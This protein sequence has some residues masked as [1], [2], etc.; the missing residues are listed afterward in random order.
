MLTEKNT[1]RV[2]SLDGLRGFA[3][4]TVLL[5]HYTYFRIGWVT[6]SLF[7]V[8]SAYLITSRLLQL[9]HLPWRAY[10]TKFFVARVARIFPLYFLALSLGFLSYRILQWPEEWPRVFPFLATFTFNLYPMVTGDELPYV[11]CHFWSLATE[12]QF[13]LLW[14]FLVLLIPRTILPAVACLFLIAAPL[15]RYYL[16]ELF[17]TS[18]PEELVSRSIYYFPL[19]HIDALGL[20]ILMATHGTSLVNALPNEP[21]KS[22]PMFR[23]LLLLL[24]M[25]LLAHIYVTTHYGGVGISRAL[26]INYPERLYQTFHHVFTMSLT[27]IGSA[28]LVFSGLT[29]VPWSQKLFENRYMVRL[30]IISYGVYVVHLPLLEAFR[31]FTDIQPRTFLGLLFFPVYIGVSVLLAEISFRYLEEPISRWARRK[32][33]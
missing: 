11:F 31:H 27:A 9:K 12:E 1:G 33:A 22:S 30:G 29:R 6:I 26:A 10:L 2:T 16:G 20:G 7:Y 24:S 25:V 17:R 4:S 18:L 13:Y 14:P 28:L 32:V 3:I 23:F 15:C 21:R 5:F 8:L 19:C